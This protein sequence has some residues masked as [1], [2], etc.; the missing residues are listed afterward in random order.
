MKRVAPQ[1][2]YVFAI[3]FFPDPNANML[4]TLWAKAVEVPLFFRFRHGDCGF[5]FL[6][7]FLPKL[8]VHGNTKYIFEVTSNPAAP[9][10][11]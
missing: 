9:T 6:Y 10:G 7:C 1:R 4:L 3:V 8:Q 11:V 2:F 5:D